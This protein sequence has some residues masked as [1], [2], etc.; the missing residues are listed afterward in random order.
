LLKKSEEF[1][2]S[3]KSYSNII[4]FIE[5]SVYDCSILASIC[6]AGVPP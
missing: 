4:C 3:S 1:D 6:T 5:F 2:T